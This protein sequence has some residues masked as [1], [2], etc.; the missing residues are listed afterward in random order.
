MLLRHRP[1]RL[2]DKRPA[3][4][5][6]GFEHL[7][8]GAVAV[9]QWLKANRVDFVLVGAV[10]E[11][12]RGS[13][14]ATGPVAIVPAPYGRNFERL[15]RA[16]S[17]ADAR[18]RIAAEEEGE[19]ETMQIKLTPEKLGRGQLWTV[20]C[21][22]HD[23]DIEARSSGSP[24]YQEVLYE[25]ARFHLAGDLSVEVASPEHIEHYAQVRRTGLSPEIRISRSA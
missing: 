22:A 16:L 25:S 7:D 14:D 19:A 2:D 13:T 18:V 4:T 8:Q 20:R 10:A 21:G 6:K 17:A 5:R 24:S 15:S 9:L 1:P 12:V 3:T 23:L 11:A